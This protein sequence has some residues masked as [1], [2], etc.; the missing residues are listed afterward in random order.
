M[1]RIAHRLIKAAGLTG[2]FVRGEAHRVAGGVTPAPAT[3]RQALDGWLA[4]MTCLPSLR[5]RVL[6][7]A[8]RNPTWIEW[9]AYC[10][11]V[12]RTM[13]YASTLAFRQSEVERI[14]PQPAPWNFWSGVR[15]IPDIALADVE[16]ESVSTADERAYEGIADS[17]ASYVVA[18][19]K[20]IE[21]EDVKRNPVAH[22]AEMEA[23]RAAMRRAG[24]ALTRI[25]RRGEYDRFLCYSGLIGDS[26]AMLEAGRRAGILTICLETW[27]WRPGHMIYNLNAPALEYNIAGWLR[28]QGEWNTAKEREVDA[29]LT[30]LDGERRTEGGWL[31]NFYRIQRD[32]L[33]AELPLQLR[34]F[35]AGDAP[36]FLLAPNVIGDS[37]ML[38]RETTF[39][40]QQSWTREVVHWFA[41]RPHLKLVVRA[42]PAEQWVGG[43]C[44]VHMGP[45]AKA[46][47]QDAPNV[48]V[49]GSEEKVNTFALI[50]FARAGLAWLSSA[51]VDFVVRGLPAMVAARPKYE[52][53]GIVV[54]PKSRQEYFAQLEHWSGCAE[55]PT[56]EQVTQGKRYLHVVFK[57]FSFEA[58]GRTYRA[59]SC[60]LGGMPNQ[61]EHDRFYRILV[62]DEQAPDQIS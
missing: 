5:G 34:Q 24:A 21:E 10:A 53:M 50:P 33:S 46:A 40:G 19:D 45:V 1:S 58:A 17:A 37:S 48:F 49:L 29:Y 18:Y 42:H 59:L 7:T 13:G 62:G 14:Y 56:P 15:R 43:K 51:G 35:L 11:C 39:A 38:C 23:A 9:G 44:V 60:R 6:I 31:D 22:R 52:G 54:E 12:L 28:A 57:G 27:A 2:R 26:P 47:A 3:A 36:V 41:A 8:A 30:F 20:H 55:R 25:L 61:S 4:A 32:K 16:A